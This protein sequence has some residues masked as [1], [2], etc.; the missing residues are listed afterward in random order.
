LLRDMSERSVFI[1]TAG[2]AVAGQA[3]GFGPMG[4]GPVRGGGVAS[5]ATAMLLIKRE[6]RASGGCLGTERR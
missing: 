1:E 2:P 5:P 6:T 4:F 3:W